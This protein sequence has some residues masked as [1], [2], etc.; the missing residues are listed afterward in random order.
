MGGSL[1]NEKDAFENVIEQIAKLKE[2]GFSPVIVH[3]GGPEIS[4]WQKKLGIE[5]EFI[6]GLRKT[7]EKTIEIVEMLLCGKVQNLILSI[8][9]R[10]SLRAV[11]LSGK[12]AG[13]FEMRKADLIDGQDLGFVGE[14]TRVKSDII[15]TLVNSD[16]VPVIACI[17]GD[18]LG[19]T[20]NINGDTVAGHIA[21]AL[22]SEILLLITNVGG[23]HIGDKVINNFNLQQ[24]EELK[25]NPEISGG[26]IPKLDTCIYALKNG[27]QHTKIVSGIEDNALLAACYN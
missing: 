26:M 10:K 12:D 2:Q 5:P 1:L 7:D 23:I 3:G 14:I 22:N 21:A 8:L 20:Y 16:Y 11:G 18:S 24:A 9:N 19:S 15:M 6:N 13:L 25:N 27:V 4:E 17:G